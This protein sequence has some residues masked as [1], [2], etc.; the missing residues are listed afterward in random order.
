[1]MGDVRLFFFQA[2]D[3]IRALYVTGVQT[4]ALPISTSSVTWPKRRRRRRLGHVTLEVAYEHPCRDGAAV[5]GA[6]ERRLARSEER[7]VGKSADGGGRRRVRKKKK[8]IA[9]ATDLSSHEH[10]VA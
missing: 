3:G 5:A 6:T 10:A 4:C 9:T 7:R 2:D 1:M 8:H